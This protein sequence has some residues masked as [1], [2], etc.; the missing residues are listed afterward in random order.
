MEPGSREILTR[1]DADA[2]GF[3]S[4]SIRAVDLESYDLILTASEAHRLRVVER[5]PVLLARTRTLLGFLDPVEDEIVDP[6]RK[7]PE[8][9]RAME[10][11]I[12]PAIEAVVA[13]LLRQRL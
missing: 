3:V 12:V 2:D 9:Y 5:D 7:S 4:T 6:Y 13:Y 1:H 10:R 8:T 11:Q